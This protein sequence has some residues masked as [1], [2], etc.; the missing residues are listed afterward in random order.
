MGEFSVLGILV[1]LVGA[2]LIASVPN[3]WFV[4]P[5]TLRIGMLAGVVLIPILIGAATV[6]LT[7][8]DPRAPGDGSGGSTGLAVRI[9]RGYPLTAVMAPL[10]A[11]LAVLALSRKIRY[12]SRGWTEDHVP[13]LVKPGGYEMVVRDLQAALA[14]AGLEMAAESA[15]PSMTV[16]A[17]I[18][19]RIAG[20]E[21]DALVP[22]GLLQLTQPDLDVLIYPSDLMVVGRP[23][24]VRRARAALAS[25]LTTSAARL[26][27]AGEA[28]ELEDRIA[29]L[30][31]RARAGVGLTPEARAELAAIDAELARRDLSFDD[32][33]VVY[34]ERLQV[35]RD[36]RKVSM[37]GR[38]ELA[39]GSIA[40]RSDGLEAA[41]V[42][43]GR[44]SVDGPR[45]A[46]SLR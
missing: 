40:G 29:T 18:L 21:A 17:R 33:Q 22:D 28:Q 15:P 37:D 4:P 25:R 43:L 14:G 24:R 19:A 11:Y 35:E 12:R 41:S 44:P 27:A 31:Q 36:L 38:L 7:R 30:G 23:E 45:A 5:S 42:P 2:R 32:W 10:L 34:R 16:P 9:L 26:T 20:P 3:P 8:S 13:L 39:D 1:P 6:A 46:A